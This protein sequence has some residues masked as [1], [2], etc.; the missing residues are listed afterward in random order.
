MPIPMVRH[1]EVFKLAEKCFELSQKDMT[2]TE[3]ARIVD[4]TKNYVNMLI[5]IMRELHGDLKPHFRSERM[6]V[7]EAY[8]IAR[9]DRAAQ[10]A[11]YRR[12]RNE[13][14]S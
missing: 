6:S 12:L 11:A 7:Q 5:L 13:P 8:S 2:G 10:M 14:S 4:R 3:I 9:Q 1:G